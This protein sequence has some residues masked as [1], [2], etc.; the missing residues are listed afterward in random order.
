[1]GKSK[2]KNKKKKSQATSSKRPYRSKSG[3]RTKVDWD[4]YK[5]ILGTKTDVEIGKQLGVSGVSVLYARRRYGIPPFGG[6]KQTKEAND[7]WDQQPLGQVSDEFLATMLDKHI[8]TVRRARRNRKIP[9][10][11]KKPKPWVNA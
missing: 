6:S 2:S 8:D 4:K 11:R 3:A 10:F 7:F 1:M 9:A 5:D